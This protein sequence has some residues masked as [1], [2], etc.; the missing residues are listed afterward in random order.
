M[1]TVSQHSKPQS[2]PLSLRCFALVWSLSYPVVCILMATVSWWVPVVYTPNCPTPSHS[3]Y[4]NT[5]QR[6]TKGS[7]TGKEGLNH[8]VRL[9]CCSFPHQ[10]FCALLGDLCTE[11][12]FP[13]LPSALLGYNSWPPL[14]CAWDT[15]K[16]R[17]YAAFPPRTIP[18][19]VFDSNFCFGTT[20]EAKLLQAA[21]AEMGTALCHQI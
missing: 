21:L 17:L 7:E 1:Y 2:G 3:L 5:F 13:F 6:C 8:L 19:H 9:P 11:H 10:A 4:L 15:Y 14:P 16:E 18:K 12:L 20:R